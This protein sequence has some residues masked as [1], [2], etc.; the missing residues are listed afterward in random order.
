MTFEKE[1]SLGTKTIPQKADFPSFLQSFL[2]LFIF[3]RFAR[4]YRMKQVL[5]SEDQTMFAMMVKMWLEQDA[6]AEVLGV[7]TNGA[8]TIRLVYEKKPDVLFQDMVLGDMSG[9]DVIRAVRKDIPQ[10]VIF[11][12]SGRANLAKLALEAGANGCMLK[13]DNPQVLRHALEWDISKGAWISPLLG[14]KFFNATQELMKY[15]FT[16]P[17]LNVLRNISLSNSE[18]ASVLG[19]S[20]GTVRNTLSSIYHKTNQNSRPH[21]ARWAHEVLLL[22]PTTIVNAHFL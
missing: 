17:E 11:V 6:R 18:I 12:L 15:S 1:K 20:E 21:I 5:I 14:E 8:D 4:L 2:K 9:I 10:L 22:T 13:E 7:A 16:N 19:L 3:Q